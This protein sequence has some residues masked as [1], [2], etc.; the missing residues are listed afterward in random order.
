MP[1]KLI[2]LSDT[3]IHDQA[4]TEFKHS[5]PDIY[6]ERIIH[7]ILDTQGELDAVI[8]S[9]DLTHDGTASACQQ[10][11]I[12]LHLLP[13]PVY[14]V[15]GNH[16]SLEMLQQHLLDQQISMPDR[17]E[18]S[19]WQL[20]FADSHVEQ[21][22]AGHIEKL[23]AQKI[24]RQLA[25]NT[26]PALLFTHHPPV[27]VNC[28]WLDEIAIDNGDDFL[29]QLSVHPQLSH[30][31]FG[32]IHQ[33]WQGQYQHITL[34]GCPSSCIQFKPDSDEFATDPIAPGYRVIQLDDDGSLATR[35]VR[36]SMQIRQIHSGGQTGVDRAALDTALRLGIAHAGWCPAG[37]RALDGV[38]PEKYQLRE[39]PSDAYPQRTEWNI[40]DTHGSLVLCLGQPEGGTALTCKLARQLDKPLLVIDMT[41]EIN[42]AAF[43]QWIYQHDIRQLNIAGPRQD[44]DHTI[45][46]LAHKILKQLLN[47]LT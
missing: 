32:H 21:Q 31:L 38:I 16:D 4:L 6:L 9:G 44:K 7:H 35:V 8:V 25:S 3:H 33:E 45:Y 47:Q 22:S 36:C 37:R 29:Q 41:Q 14:V 27:P 30:I 19:H 10:L 28:N 17:I 2:Q 39:T 1:I 34:L 15:A 26:K 23:H 46:G 11:S 24:S 20:L 5:T 13:V 42:T 18:L 43:N 12:L 40:R